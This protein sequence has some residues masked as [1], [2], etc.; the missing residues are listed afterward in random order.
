[1]TSAEISDLRSL[2][3]EERERLLSSLQSESDKIMLRLLLETGRSLD[4]LQEARVADLDRDRSVLR[5]RREDA[6]EGEAEVDEVP[7]SPELS[8]AVGGYLDKNPG[9]TRIFE[10]RCGKPVGPKWFR[11][12]IEPVVEKLGL[13]SPR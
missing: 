2:G 10:G 5:L 8:E 1:M 4:V 6:E 12:A 3:P 9:K 7:L 11:C 13:G